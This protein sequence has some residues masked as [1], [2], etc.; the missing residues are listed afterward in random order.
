MAMEKDIVVAFEFGSSQIRGMAGYKHNDGSVKVLAFE[1]VDAR[2]CV[3]KG[4]VYNI[5]KTVMCLRNI[6]EKMESTLGEH[7]TKAYVGL[8][9]RSLNSKK[10]SVERRFAAKTVITNDILDALM[11][12]NAAI[13]YPGYEILAVVPQEYNLGVDTT[14]DPVG[15]MSDSIQGMY[16]NVIARTDMKE[17]VQRCFQTCGV[18]VA[19]YFITPLV[20]ASCVLTDA[21]RRSGCAFVDFGYGVTSI[22]VYKGGL[23]RHVAVVPLG[24]NNI[25]QD[26]CGEM[27]EESEAEELKVKYSSAYADLSQESVS[28]K[29]LSNNGR[30]MCEK[31]LLDIVEARQQEILANVHAQIRMSG[32]GEK[33]IAGLVVTGGASNIKDMDKAIIERVKPT[34]IRFV[35]SL[36][37]KVQSEAGVLP[38]DATLNAILSILCEGK[39]ACTMRIVQPEPEPE[40][41]LVNESATDTPPVEPV[42]VAQETPAAETPQED[43]VRTAGED[44]GDRQKSKASKWVKFK[45]V[46]E[47]IAN[48][49]TEE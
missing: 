35:K 40:V 22:S 34:K 8:S 2:N 33:L 31:D 47:R 6:T 11:R 39:D 25:T 43:V 19:G 18:E 36:P 13:S 38:V 20:T 29:V 16:L 14:A 5:D 46:F 28:K 9:G 49:I 42:E 10:N 24:G 32:Y 3:H 4:I 26:L 1:Q 17:Y 21:E 27:L 15:V 12:E 7:I 23:L 30:A 41:E 48:T 45:K 44:A 37:V